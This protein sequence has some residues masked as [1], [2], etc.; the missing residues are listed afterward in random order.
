MLHTSP[1][2]V[3]RSVPTRQKSTLP[4]CMSCPPALSAITVCGTPCLREF[5]GGEASALVARPRLVDPDMDRQPGIVRGVDRR[6]RRAPVDGG[7][8]AG[9]AVGQHLQALAARLQ[10]ADF[11]QAMLADAPADLDVF[12]ADLGGAPVGRL[13]PPGRRQRS[14]QGTQVVERPAQVHRRRP[15]LQQHPV[16]ARQH[17]IGRVGRHGERHAVGGGGADQRR[18]AHDHG[19]DGALGVFH[20]LEVAH[21]EGMRQQRLVD[22]LH[23]RAVGAEPDRA[24]GFAV[25]SHRLTSLS[26]AARRVP[27]RSPS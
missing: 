10:A 26:R 4:R 11:R 12:V 3:V 19:A 27:R 9:V 25:D 18:A 16:G 5:P 14:Q 8:P 7:Q 15:G 6:Q 17:G 22:R 21:D 1:L 23:G 20:G 13:A 24:I 2:R